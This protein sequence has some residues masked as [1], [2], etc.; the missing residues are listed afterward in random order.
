MRRPNLR[1][2][3]RERAELGHPRSRA[4]LLS[5]G[6]CG[7]AAA[8]HTV[9]SCCSISRVP[10]DSVAAVND[11]AR[12]K[13]MAGCSQSCSGFHRKVDGRPPRRRSP[14]AAS[15]PTTAATAA[16][17]ARFA[18]PEG[19]T[20]APRVPGCSRIRAPAAGTAGCASEGPGPGDAPAPGFQRRAGTWRRRTPARQAP[21]A[22]RRGGAASG[23]PLRAVL[24]ICFRVLN[25][26]ALCRQILR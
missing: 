19:V 21:Q 12:C 10:V 5:R 15:A 1:G 26:C 17:G 11:A 2:R 13:A 4:G 3:D 23:R 18:S 6:M 16:S 8:T 9:V 24:A 7:S 25:G 14:A 22:V 20:S